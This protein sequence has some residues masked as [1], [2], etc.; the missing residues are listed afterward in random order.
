MVRKRARCDAP[1]QGPAPGPQTALGRSFIWKSHMGGGERLC[2]C[3]DLPHVACSRCH[4][5]ESEVECRIMP[6]KK[7]KKKRPSRVCEMG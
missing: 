2:L 5:W 7:K 3:K 1:R 6:A 4:P